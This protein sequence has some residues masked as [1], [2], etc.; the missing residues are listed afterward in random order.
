[1]THRGK[2]CDPRPSVIEKAI[3]A[4]RCAMGSRSV[5][6]N[7]AFEQSCFGWQQ[8]HR[9]STMTEIIPGPKG[10][11]LIGNVLDIDPV[12][13]VVCLGRIADTYGS[14][15]RRIRGESD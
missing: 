6:L 8:I 5:G 2:L 1:M 7:I 13:A 11:P 14:S 9:F 15:D 10:L 12:D 4:E 3:D